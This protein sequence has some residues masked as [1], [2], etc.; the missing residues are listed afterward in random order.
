MSVV[1]PFLPPLP[2]NLGE[3]CRHLPQEARTTESPMNICLRA[4]PGVDGYGVM[5]SSPVTDRARAGIRAP[6][7]NP[8]PC[9]PNGQHIKPKPD[10]NQ[11]FVIG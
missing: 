5:R 1:N 11:E 9:I 3:S 7:L 4:T 8:F 6:D 2:P 10:D